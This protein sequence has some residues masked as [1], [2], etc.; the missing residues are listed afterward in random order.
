[1]GIQLRKVRNRGSKQTSLEAWVFLAKFWEKKT[2]D[3]GGLQRTCDGLSRQV[4]PWT[5]M[6]ATVEE[7][8]F[9]VKSVLFSWK[10][11]W[12]VTCNT[13]TA[14]S[15][16]NQYSKSWFF[17]ILRDMFRDGCQCLRTSVDYL[18][19]VITLQ[20]CK[21][22]DV[23]S[24]SPTPLRKKFPTVATIVVSSTET[25]CVTTHHVRNNKFPFISRYFDF[26]ARD[27][28]YYALSLLFLYLL[29]APFSV[30]DPYTEKARSTRN[31]LDC[32]MQY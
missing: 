21:F 25:T 14:H 24:A 12:M 19:F 27:Y 7:V 9:E 3:Y 13:S 1:M 2:L 8:C 32:H 31:I 5:T 11:H 4:S 23:T 29:Y 28:T 15:S 26:I 10:D 22:L 16:V 6:A 18:I 17:E 20:I 30:T